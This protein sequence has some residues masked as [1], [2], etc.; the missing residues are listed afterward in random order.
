[1][2]LRIKGNSLRLR[3][4]QKEAAL[5][6]NRGLVESHIEFAPDRSLAYLIEGS[7]NAETMS[8]PFDGYAIR[9]TIPTHELTDWVESDQVGIEARSKTGLELLVEKDFKC[10]HRSV[11]Q[12][13]D[14]YPHPL[15]TCRG[16]Q[17]QRLGR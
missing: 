7:P 17:R 5:V 11:E 1:M 2:K 14:A 10:L 9:V 16:E 12:E 3:L 4:T 13:P 15:M 8:A 6:R